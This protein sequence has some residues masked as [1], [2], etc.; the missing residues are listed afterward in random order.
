VNCQVFHEIVSGENVARTALRF[1][2]SVN[3]DVLLAN[4]DEINIST[5][6]RLDIADLLTRNSK[7][8][9]LTIEPENISAKYPIIL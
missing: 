9:V 2:E 8:Q 6:A 5:F 7:L 3:A 4:P 1:A